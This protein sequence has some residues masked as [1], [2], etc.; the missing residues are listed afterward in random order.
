MYQLSHDNIQDSHSGT[1]TISMSEV[2]PSPTIDNEIQK[3]DTNLVCFD[4]K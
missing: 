3:N 4:L 1:D 2:Y